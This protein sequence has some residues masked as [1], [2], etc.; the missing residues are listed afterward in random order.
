MPLKPKNQNIK[1]KKYR[2]KF[3]SVIN[4]ICNN[5]KSRASEHRYM[6]AS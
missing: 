2:N 5:L 4:S 3:K 6:M 1:Q